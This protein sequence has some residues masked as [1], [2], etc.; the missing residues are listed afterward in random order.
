MLLTWKWSHEILVKKQTTKYCVW[1]DV[2]ENMKVHTHVKTKGYIF[3]TYFSGHLSV[4][5]TDLFQTVACSSGDDFG[6]FFNWF[7]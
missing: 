4:L 6:G 3:S 7:L 1:R 5:L 2:S